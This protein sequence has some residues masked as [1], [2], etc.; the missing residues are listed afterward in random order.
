MVVQA[1][2]RQVPLAV[3]GDGLDPVGGGECGFGHDSLLLVSSYG[4]IFPASGA[5]SIRTVP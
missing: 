2:Y 4:H 3:R 5:A 1:A